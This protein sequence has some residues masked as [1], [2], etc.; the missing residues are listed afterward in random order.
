MKKTWQQFLSNIHLSC[1]GKLQHG[2][3]LFL[4]GVLQDDD[5]MFAWSILENLPE[6]RGDRGED[7]LMSVDGGPVSAGQGH[8]HEVLLG[9]K[10]SEGGGHIQTEVIPAETVLLA[11][12]HG[13][14]VGGDQL[15]VSFLV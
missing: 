8:V 4:A 3:G 10:I 13:N 7:D 2:L 5:W 9:V 6:V 15:L 14:E 11:G 12:P 1:V